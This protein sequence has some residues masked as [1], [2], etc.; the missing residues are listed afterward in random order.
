MVGGGDRTVSCAAARVAS[1]PTAL[2]VLPLGTANDFART[3]TTSSEQPVTLDGEIS[4]T[5]PPDFEVASNAL[6]VVPTNSRA[7]T[8]DTPHETRR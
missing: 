4:G 2:G 8:L 6:N 3:I 7:A 5:T 1:T